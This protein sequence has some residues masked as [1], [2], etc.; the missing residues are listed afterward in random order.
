[1]DREDDEEMDRGEDGQEI[2]ERSCKNVSCLV[3]IKQLKEE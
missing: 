2:I 3:A 1:M